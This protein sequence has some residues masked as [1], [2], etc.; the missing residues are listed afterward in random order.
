MQAYRMCKIVVNVLYMNASV[1]CS[2]KYVESY[3]SNK[4]KLVR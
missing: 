3:D 1:E 2:T 4:N